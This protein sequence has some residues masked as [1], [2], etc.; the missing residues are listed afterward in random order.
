VGDEKADELQSTAVATLEELE[1]V[2]EETVQA[3]LNQEIGEGLIDESKLDGGD[4]EAEETRLAA[5]AAEAAADP[6]SGFEQ[7]VADGVEDTEA[8]ADV[9]ADP[10]DASETAEETADETADATDEKNEDEDEGEETDPE[11]P[12]A[13]PGRTD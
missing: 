13:E 9:D 3:E 7:K 5:A 2:I 8:D 1:R 10:D 6:F 4:V 11:D 12:D